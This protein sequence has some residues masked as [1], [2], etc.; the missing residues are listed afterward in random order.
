MASAVEETTR[1]PH[2]K[3][4]SLQRNHNLLCEF[5]TSVKLTNAITKAATPRKP[6]THFRCCLTRLPV[7]LTSLLPL[8]PGHRSL[9]SPQPAH[10]TQSV[11]PHVTACASGSLTKAPTAFKHPQKVSAALSGSTAPAGTLYRLHRNSTTY[12]TLMLLLTCSAST[13][14]A[15]LG[16]NKHT[17]SP[18]APPPPQIAAAL[19][20]YTRAALLGDNNSS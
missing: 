14:A 18:S 20:D 8:E 10:K 2:A 16:N 3:N 15:L 9:V 4:R 1:R 19:S 12:G 6:D 7:L 5:Q 17:N 11:P 13:R